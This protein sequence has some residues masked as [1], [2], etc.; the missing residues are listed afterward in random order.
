MSSIIFLNIILCL[1]E[2]EKLVD[3]VIACRLVKVN[4][5]NYDLQQE[6]YSINNYSSM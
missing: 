4:P 1:I 5:D 3:K 2:Y 6:C